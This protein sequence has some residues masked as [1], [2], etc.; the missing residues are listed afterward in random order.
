MKKDKRPQNTPALDKA[1]VLELLAQGANKRDLAKKLGLKGS[2]RIILKRILK[3][4]QA[5]GAIEGSPKKGFIKHGE[6]PEAGLIEVT[7]LDEDGE[8][9]A[10][11]LNWDSNE[12]PPLI[13]VMPPRDGGAPGLGDRLLAR[14]EKHGEAYE[15]RIIRR[16]ERETPTRLIG[17]LR[18]SPATGWRLVP[19][20]KKARTEY[21][22]DKSDLNGAKHNELVAAEP[23]PGRI[24][25]FARV[26][27][28][29]RIGS[30]D[31]PKTV[32]LIAIHDHGIPV[33]F[34]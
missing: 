12:E 25:G 19:I 23:K 11:P 9:L 33:E 22:L 10:R 1:R 31:S 8:L 29:E 4:L 30:M 15:A 3:E 5:E 21:A 28:A 34:P 26:K 13:Y 18:N 17:V 6:L 20:D 27:V 32:S 2:D 16:L 7:G 14:L 24:A